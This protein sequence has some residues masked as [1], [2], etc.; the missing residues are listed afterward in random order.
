MAAAAVES[1]PHRR[2][3]YGKAKPTGNSARYTAPESLLKP[4]PCPVKV[5]DLDAAWT[6]VHDAHVAGDIKARG[7][8]LKAYSVMALAYDR[9]SV[10]SGP[11]PFISFVRLVRPD[12]MIGPHHWLLARAFERVASK[13]LLRLMIFMPPGHSKSLFASILLPAWLYGLNAKGRILAASHS[14]SF[15]KDFGRQIRD[16]LASDAY[17][18]L[19]P[20]TV[21]RRDV[22]AAD[23]WRTEAGGQ[24]QAIGVGAAAAGRRADMLGVIDDPISEQDAYSEAGRKNVIQWYPS[25]RNRLMAH[26][27]LVLMMTRWHVGDLAGHILSD[28]KNNARGGAE[29]W[30]VIKVPAIL[31]QE[32]AKLINAALPAN[33]NVAPVRAGECPFPELW[34]IEEMRAL[35]AT[36]PPSYWSA[37]YMQDP[38]TD[39][40][41]IYRREWWKPWRGKHMPEVTYLL[42]V[43]DTAYGSEE[44]M[45]DY[46]ACTV[47]G[48]FDD[49]TDARGRPAIML[50]G[51]YHERKSF[52]ELRNESFDYW[53]R[54][55]ESASGP[56]DQVLIEAKA[57]GKSLIQ[58]MQ[59]RGVPVM[60]WNPERT[61]RGKEMSQIACASSASTMLY[62]GRVY[63]P[64]GKR[65]A[66]EVIEECA[67]LPF[68]DHD[69]LASTVTIALIWLRR[70]TGLVISGEPGDRED[71]PTSDDI[72]AQRAAVRPGR[73]EVEKFNGNGNGNG[74]RLAS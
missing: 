3:T 51:R 38:T 23:H 34:P 54:W 15:V 46:N 8:A 22:R 29:Q 33:D 26:T 16:L 68:G 5:H 71:Q 28:A 35:Q 42:Q 40:G 61:T 57:S 24:Y 9:W 14:S 12:L 7:V 47:W 1:A 49:P 2:R 66:Q 74:R 48:V 45:G 62:A 20:G 50:L 64:E 55:D 25:Y 43:W 37:L 41:N 27:P 59:L 39:G 53:Q 32:A 21:V 69:D 72:L 44:E 65:W 10:R 4:A 19:F 11:D 31:T 56:V 67:Q 18:R 60:P 70:A 58:E 30:E 6:K 63:Y 73:P 17:R 52:P 36:F 13:S